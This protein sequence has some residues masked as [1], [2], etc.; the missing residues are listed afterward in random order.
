[1]PIATTAHAALGARIQAGDLADVR[2]GR[3][4]VASPLPAAE[5][6][7]S[8]SCRADLRPENLA[9]DH[10]PARRLGDEPR[11]RPARS[12][13]EQGR[14]GPD[15]RRRRSDPQPGASTRPATSDRRRSLQRRRA[16]G[17]YAATYPTRGIILDQATSPGTAIAL[18]TVLDLS[19]DGS[20]ELPLSVRHG[21]TAAQ[22]EILSPCPNA[23]ITTIT[24]RSFQAA[25][26]GV[27]RSAIS[28]EDSPPRRGQ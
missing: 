16:A 7:R 26:P 13:R 5:A 3:I 12:R 24:S 4:D 6:R 1:M 19:E 18:V 14:A 20:P 17:L 2:A 15:A 27:H 23:A 9:A 10:R 28:A 25:S 21:V 8:C 22:T 11:D